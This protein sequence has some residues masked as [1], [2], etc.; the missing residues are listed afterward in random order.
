MPLAP[1][2]ATPIHTSSLRIAER[3]IR[4]ADRDHPADATLR[5]ELQVRRAPTP[6]E[7]AKACR[8]VFSYYR[9]LGWLEEGGPLLNQLQSSL[10]LAD[11]FAKYPRSFADSE[12]VARAVPSWVRSEI[13]VTPA[14]ARAL[15]QEPKLWLRARAGQGIALAERLGDCRPFGS[16]A[17]ADILEY[18]GGQDLFRTAAF[19]AGDFEL[20][21][22]SSQTAGLV[23]APRPGETWWDAC[24]GEGGKMLHLSD[25]MGNKGLIWASDRSAWRLQKLKRRA[26]RARVFNYRA[27][28]WD[29]G[30]KL[31]TKTKF[32]GVLIDA[33]CSGTGTWQRNPHARWTTTAQDVEE[34]SELQKQLL[35]HAAPAVKP[36]GKLIYAVCALTHS[37]TEGVAE[38]F[39]KRFRDF[40]ALAVRH[41]LA[42]DGGAT[43][44]LVLRPQQFGGN[45]MFIATWLRH[46]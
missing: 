9:W 45:G 24:A 1:G 5:H 23:C 38:A 15:Q 11:R 3:V 36:G 17:L 25:L 32:D 30:P 43:A 13:E 20:Q 26:A 31:P 33:P 40:S 27:T 2:N 35:A 21:D 44:R 29:G 14:W 19:H 18:Q 4:A 37:E 39:E 12:L 42:A 34:L 28:P 7:A 46:R 8:A 6:G 10:Q 41:P 22:I 16:G